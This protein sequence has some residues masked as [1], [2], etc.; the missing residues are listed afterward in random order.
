MK[1]AM[2]TNRAIVFSD[3]RKGWI[4]SILGL[5]SLVGHP[6]IFRAN[7]RIN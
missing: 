2:K 4:L 3:L 6:L 7:R 5:V 1:A